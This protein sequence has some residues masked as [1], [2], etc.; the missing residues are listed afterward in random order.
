MNNQALQHLMSLKPEYVHFEVKGVKYQAKQL[1]EAEFKKYQAEIV[2]FKEGERVFHSEELVGALI[3]ACLCDEE[4]NKVFTEKDR[5]LVD[6][7]PRVV[8][9]EIFVHAA[10]INGVGQG[11]EE[12]AKN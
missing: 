6:Q 1:S 3:F 8:L 11:K 10:A 2:E 7:I 12:I 9:N 5:A 4:G